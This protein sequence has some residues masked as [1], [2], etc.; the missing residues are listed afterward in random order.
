MKVIGDSRFGTH[1]WR[2]LLLAS[3]SGALLLLIAALGLAQWAAGHARSETDTEARQNSRA[4]LGLLE[5]ELQ[6]FRLLPRVLP[7]FPM[8][9]WRSRTA[10][11]PPGRGSTAS[12][13]NWQSGPT[14]R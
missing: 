1:P 12:W 5:S 13:N 11:P 14:L 10:A 3:I 6:K 2:R 9:A 7:N 8:S 4:H